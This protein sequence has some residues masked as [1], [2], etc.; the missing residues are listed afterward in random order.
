MRVFFV[1]CM[2]FILTS[3]VFADWY[4]NGLVEYE[5]HQETVRS[6]LVSLSDL[7]Q[8][9]SED[10]MSYNEASISKA[11]SSVCAQEYISLQEQCKL[12]YTSA[13]IRESWFSRILFI[14][15]PSYE[16]EKERLKNMLKIVSSCHEEECMEKMFYRSSSLMDTSQTVEGFLQELLQSLD[17]LRSAFPLAPTKEQNQAG[18]LTQPWVLDRP[19]R[20]K[21][22][23]FSSFPALSQQTM[24]PID[25]ETV[26]RR[27]DVFSGTVFSHAYTSHTKNTERFLEVSAIED[28][29]KEVLYAQGKQVV[30]DRHAQEVDQMITSVMREGSQSL[31][32]GLR[33]S[34]APEI[35]QFPFEELQ[36]TASLRCEAL[37]Y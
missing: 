26:Q 33:S 23:S 5:K 6:A 32:D 16:E 1:G 15:P 21:S 14:S 8:E 25:V 20:T 30:F 34:F 4:T 31:V 24:K 12:A 10:F 11:L 35:F 27:F 28:E 36:K 29:I 22:Y 13:K 37:R 3:S 2:F 19:I 7:T 9:E 18:F 17:A